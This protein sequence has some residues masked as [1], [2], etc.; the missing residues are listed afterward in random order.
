[1]V[2]G[3]ANEAKHELNQSF[4]ISQSAGVVTH[5]SLSLSLIGLMKNWEGDY[6]EGANIISEALQIAREHELTVP[7]LKP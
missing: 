1:M 2:N 6:A 5:Q 7:L 3:R 4:S